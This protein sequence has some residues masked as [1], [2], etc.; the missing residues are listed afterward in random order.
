MKDL[1]FFKT[2]QVAIA[3]FVALFCISAFFRFYHLGTPTDKVF[4]EVYFPVFAQN[5]L[6]KTDFYDAHPPL[7]KLIIASG[8]ALKGDNPVG[9]RVMNAVTGLLL[10]G[11]IAGF[12]YSLTKRWPA[13]FLATL[14]VAID[15]MA[16]I[17]SR[18]G[19]INIYLA[20]FSL[21]GLWFFWRW[22]R[23]KQRTSDILIACCAFGLAASVKWIG[24]GT[25]ATA[26]VFLVIATFLKLNPTFKWRPLQLLTLLL[27]P[28][29]Y[30]LTFIPDAV[31]GQDIAWWHTSAYGYHAHL[32]ATHPYGSS[33]W[34]WAITYRPLWL[35]Y[36][37]MQD[38]VIG[39]IEIG[40]VVTWIG[41]LIIMIGTL[42]AFAR[43]TFLRLFHKDT[44]AV[45][46]FLIISYLGLY[47]PWIFISRV[48]FI[49]HYFVPV[50][51][52][53]ILTGIVFDH[54]FTQKSPN[55]LIAWIILLGGT[56]FFFYFL[57]L[58]IG[59]P[60]P[61]EWYQQHMW[62]RSWI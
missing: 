1:S 58:L 27:I 23:E 41:G 2:K 55:R 35:Y 46:L 15:P 50:L 21:I 29:A 22:W 10:L 36:Q 24:L 48:Q 5:Y 33:W 30:A 32:T 47:L 44:Y 39:I 17:E 31:R 61:T 4:D 28:L 14:L 45:S 60:F 42:I 20:F 26:I 53:L 8:I 40:N 9:W 51:L 18:I 6:T 49:Y 3:A 12:T 54:W 38:H 34:S 13:A 62:L 43:S 16:L 25:F 19:L 59:L 37:S 56:L 52:L 11:V 7:G 57:P